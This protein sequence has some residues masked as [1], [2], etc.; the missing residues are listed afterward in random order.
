MAVPRRTMEE[1]M[2]E[3]LNGATRLYPIVGDP[4]AQVKSPSGV[5]RTPERL[6]S[7]DFFLLSP[8][9]VNGA[10]ITRNP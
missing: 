5:T 2:S 9:I 10:A 4:I 6:A 1:D 3:N 7:Q 8:Y